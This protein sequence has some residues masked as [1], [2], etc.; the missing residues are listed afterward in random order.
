MS[1]TKLSSGTVVARK[2]HRCDW[3]GESIPKNQKYHRESGPYD[4]RM[5]TVRHHEECLRACHE[6]ARIMDVWD[7]E[8]YDP[9]SYYRGAPVPKGCV[10][11]LA[12]YMFG[13][14]AT[15]ATAQ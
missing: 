2:P 6:Y 12:T 4:G 5:Q 3:C 8:G 1:Y 15:K 13:D 7:D 14:W 9:Y 10:D 11:E